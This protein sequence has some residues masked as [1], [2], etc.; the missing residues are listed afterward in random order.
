MI[1]HGTERLSCR[2][3]DVRVALIGESTDISFYRVLMDLGLSEY[4]PKP[5]TRDMVQTRLRTKL[6]TWRRS[7]VDQGQVW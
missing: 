6:L 3:A 4:L 7:D 5:L 2:L 1:H